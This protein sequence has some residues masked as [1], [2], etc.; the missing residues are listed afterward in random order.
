AKVSTG[1]VQSPARK[2]GP[3]VKT[4]AQIAPAD[5]TPGRPPPPVI[6][7][8]TV[9]KEEVCEGEENLITVKAHTLDGTDADLQYFIGEGRGSSV[10]IRSYRPPAGASPVKKKIVVRAGT[11]PA[12]TVDVPDFKVKD[13]KPQRNLLVGYRPVANAPDEYEFQARLIEEPG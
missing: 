10:P 4:P 13:C 11:N 12:V 9:E 2:P 7:E 1:V 5:P 6:D 3:A 8:I